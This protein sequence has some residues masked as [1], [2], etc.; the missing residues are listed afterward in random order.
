MK[1]MI[2]GWNLEGRGLS[3]CDYPRLGQA[4]RIAGDIGTVSASTTVSG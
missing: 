4:T 3:V 2:L 1:I